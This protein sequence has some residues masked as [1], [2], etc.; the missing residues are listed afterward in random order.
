MSL[1]SEEVRALVGRTATYVAPEPL[2]RAAIRYFAMATGD[3]NPLHLAGDLAPPTLVCETNQFVDLPRDVNGFAGH[4]WGF[5][6]PGTREV[7]GGNSYRFHRPVRPE[8]VVTTHWEVTD[9]TE[10][11][12]GGGQAMVI[13]T[14]LATYTNQEGHLL[15]ENEETLIY[16][17]VPTR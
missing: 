4:G 8:D 1:L 15:V 6:L 7:R 11:V 5:H 3:D 10:R 9:V 2:G 13:V 16:V 12:T 17:E 14:S